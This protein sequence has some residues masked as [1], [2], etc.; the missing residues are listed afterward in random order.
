M[1]A[2]GSNPEGVDPEPPLGWTSKDD[3]K[4]VILYGATASPPT[5]A[6]KAFLIAKGVDFKH[7]KKNPTKTPYK[8]IPILNVAG[9]QVN[10][11]FI[12][13]KYLVPALGEE[14][15]EEWSD[16]IH[17]VLDTTFRKTLTKPDTIK[18]VGQFGVPKCLA[19]CCLANLVIKKNGKAMDEKIAWNKGY[20]I[21]DPVEIAK[22]FKAALNSDADKGP[23]TFF[24][25][26]EPNTV[27]V[28]FYGFLVPLVKAN[29]DLAASMMNEGGLQDWFDNMKKKIP[30]ERLFRYD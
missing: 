19:A 4:D 6:V 29:T 1:L 17:K 22:E 7:Y 20:R 9:R 14:F 8:K 5:I 23:K 24:G 16:K 26:N 11:S 3:L 12:I 2:D 30:L 15:N 13:F 25:G 10:D 28:D 27:D 18:L 21:G